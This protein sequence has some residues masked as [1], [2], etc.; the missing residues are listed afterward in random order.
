MYK[1]YER[2]RRLL[3]ET[4]NEEITQLKMRILEL[5]SQPSEYRYSSTKVLSPEN[6]F[7]EQIQFYREKNL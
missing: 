1:K 2:D 4:Y 6:V 5:Q 3:I 7:N